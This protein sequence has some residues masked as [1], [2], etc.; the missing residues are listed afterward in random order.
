MIDVLINQLQKDYPMLKLSTLEGKAILKVESFISRN[1]Y[2]KIYP[3]YT[4]FLKTYGG[5]SFMSD[6][7]S[8]NIYGFDRNV[9][10]HL[11]EGEGSLVD[12]NGLFCLGDYTSNQDVLITEGFYIKVDD[13]IAIFYSK[14]NDANDSQFS[15]E[16]K[17]KSFSKLLEGLLQK[18]KEESKDF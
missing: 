18:T 1:E 8:F 4:Y 11:E 6:K 14:N 15:Y 10:M 12:E 16:K 7:S 3:E 2:L 17:F 9:S 13:P 5:M